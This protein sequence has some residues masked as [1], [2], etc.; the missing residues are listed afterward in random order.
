MYL[1][2]DKIWKAALILFKLSVETLDYFLHQKMYFL[3][4]QKV[5]MV[6]YMSFPLTYEGDIILPN[7]WPINWTLPK[8]NT[9]RHL[10]L[11]QR[12][13]YSSQLSQQLPR[14]FYSSAI[15]PRIHISH[16]SVRRDLK[17]TTFCHQTGKRKYCLLRSVTS[18]LLLSHYIIWQKVICYLQSPRSLRNYTTLLQGVTKSV[19]DGSLKKDNTHTYTIK[20]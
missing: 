9:L 16:C 15:L 13:R 5:K 11:I 19:W 18:R 4:T 20:Q 8:W 17:L 2:K 10:P 3:S 12:A 14:M 6:T 7:R 1:E